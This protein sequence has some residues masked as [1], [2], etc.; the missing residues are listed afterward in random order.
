[1]RVKRKQ[2]DALSGGLAL[3]KFDRGD[4]PLSFVALLAEFG[5]APSNPESLPP[6]SPQDSLS[7]S[8]TNL[9][10]G[11]T[12]RHEASDPDGITFNHRHRPDHRSARAIRHRD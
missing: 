3:G 7:A 5:H 8:N 12:A 9:R 4:W 2:A 6:A 11:H 10:L 1:M